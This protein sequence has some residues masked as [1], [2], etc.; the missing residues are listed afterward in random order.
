MP[1]EIRQNS[2]W[3]YG[4]FVV[5]GKRYCVNLGVKVPARSAAS[6]TSPA[7]IASRAAAQTK[8]E[9]AIEEA[10][11]KQGAVRLIER[12]YEIKTGSPVD[13]VAIDALSSLWRELPR[14]RVASTQYLDTSCS[15][16]DRFARFMGRRFS[17]T[18]GRGDRQAE[19]T[20]GQTSSDV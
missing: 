3:W 19:R 9:A 12:I 8:L 15:T 18:S 17:A 20:R 16:L 11:S 13:V 5:D 1:L 10:R 6:P 7:F 2:R 4:R 14:K